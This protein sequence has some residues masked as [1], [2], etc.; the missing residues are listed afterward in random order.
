MIKLM[1]LLFPIIVVH[2]TIK[3]VFN[4]IKDI[5]DYIKFDVLDEYRAMKRITKGERK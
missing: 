1:W 4:E 2:V 5:P 3:R